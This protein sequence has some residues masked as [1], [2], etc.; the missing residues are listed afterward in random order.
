M[1]P[2][3]MHTAIELMQLGFDVDEIQDFMQ[4]RSDFENIREEL[5]AVKDS[6][7]QVYEA[8]SNPV[9]KYVDYKSGWYQDIDG[10]LYQYDGVVWDVV[11][12]REVGKLEFLG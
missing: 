5:L 12:G 6:L 11:P 4:S 3:S 1:N 7:E 8:K 10:N 2:D 9:S